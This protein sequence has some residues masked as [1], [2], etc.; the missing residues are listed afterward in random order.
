MKE[1]PNESVKVKT[2]KLE[3]I[4]ELE[5]F[6]RLKRLAKIEVLPV[7][8]TKVR[9]QSFGNSV[10][11]FW[12]L[13]LIP[14]K[15]DGDHSHSS[16]IYLYLDTS[17]TCEAMA[18]F[19][20]TFLDSEGKAIPGFKKGSLEFQ[21]FKDG[22]DGAYHGCEVPD[23]YLDDYLRDGRLRIKCEMDVFLGIEF[24]IGP[25]SGNHAYADHS[26]HYGYED[27]HS[28][29]RPS[30]VGSMTKTLDAAAVYGQNIISPT[31]LQP[32]VSYT[33]SSHATYP[34]K[35]SF[36][37]TQASLTQYPHMPQRRVAYVPAVPAPFGGDRM[38]MAAPHTLRW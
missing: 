15:V 9:T 30:M 2:S 1:S 3:Y 25:G 14:L 23:N 17:K 29:V 18:E 31:I 8:G 22:A 35:T 24:P 21:H 13:E 16:Q 7:D 38:S 10:S 19:C 20:I 12:F 36:S 6:M 27:L 5:D 32:H 34:G 33:G 26:S 28:S 4:W 11:G 37:S